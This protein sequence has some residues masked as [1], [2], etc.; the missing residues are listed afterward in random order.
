ME[1]NTGLRDAISWLPD[2]VLG[3]ILSLLPTKQ[4][5]ST[6]VLAKKWRHVFRLVHTLDFDDSVLLQPEEGKEEW[7]VIRESFRNFVDR[8]LA[9]QSGFPINNFSLK[10]HIH[11]SREMAYVSAWI[12]NALERG[13][14]EMSLSLKSDDLCGVLLRGCP[15]LEELYVRHENCEGTPYCICSPN[16]KKLSLP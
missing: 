12:C 4:A 9:L 5:A 15:V 13:V 10:F 16:I 6:S 14:L 1:A 2:E 3:K 7:P 8:T 11:E